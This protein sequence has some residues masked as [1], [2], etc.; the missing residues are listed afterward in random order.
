MRPTV[1][2]KKMTNA[3]LISGKNLK[4]SGQS[5]MPKWIAKSRRNSRSALG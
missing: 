2:G 5:E 3:Q 1:E 4:M